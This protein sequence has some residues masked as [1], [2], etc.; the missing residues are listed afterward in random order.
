[1]H[2]AE[3]MKP[4]GRRL[5]LYGRGPISVRGDAAPV[6]DGQSVVPHP[7]MRWH[8][9]EGE[10]VIYAAHR[11]RRPV[12]ATA[13]R[14][15]NPLAPTTDP[16][17]PTELPAGDWDVAVF[18]NRFPSL[19]WQPTPLPDVPETSVAPAKGSAEVIVFSQDPQASLGHLDDRRIET[20]LRVIAERTCALAA[21]GACYVLPF[22]NRGEEMG[23]TLHHPHAQIYAYGFVPVRQARMV[24]QLV[25]YR[26]AN[27]RDLV[28]DLAARSLEGEARA[29]DVRQGAVSFVPAF[30]RFPYEIWITPRRHAPDLASLDESELRDMAAVLGAALRR[31]DGLWSRPMPYLLSV[32]QAPFDGQPHPE[33]TLRIEIWPIRRSPDKLKYLAGTELAAG[34][35][36]SDVLPE[37]AAQALKAVRA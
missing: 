7:H 26:S 24:A 27:R 8:P 36:A 21:Q 37:E 34:V 16:T 22:E 31:L 2:R 29:I 14:A 1:M 18:E 13:R 9:L 25:A 23:V 28:G 4:D 12:D 15:S 5:W 10:W 3:F 20:V 30:A 6:P 19:T 35:F 33:W 17:C 32:N 11:Q